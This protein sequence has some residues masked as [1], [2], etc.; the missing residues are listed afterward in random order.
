V[1]G[2][3]PKNHHVKIVT[4]DFLRVH[5][6]WKKPLLLGYSGGTDSKALLY[7]L[8]E[9]GVKPDLAHVDHGW[10]EE[11]KE[12]AEA[13]REEALELGCKFFSVRLDIEKKEDAARTA[14]YAYFQSLMKDYSAL[15]L[16]H[17]A[18]DLAETTLK[19]ILEGAHLSYL[20]GMQPVSHRYGMQIWR[21]LLTV[22]RSEI[23]SYLQEKNVKAIVDASN[24]NPIYLR[25]RMRQ[26]I[27][28]FLDKAFGKKTM[29]NLSL[30][31]KRSAELKEYLDEKTRLVSLQCGSWGISADLNGYAR[32]EQRHILQKMARKKNLSLS[33]EVLETLLDWLAE[34]GKEKTLLLGKWKLWVGDGGIF[35]FLL[36]STCLS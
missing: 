10:R 11:S 28:P 26:E 18:D 5:W 23:Y 31:S 21:P 14:R 22:K 19:R 7:A 30:L 1:Q 3:T 2:I 9:C 20:S 32:I 33:K 13:L 16:A 27:F 4:Y 12:E 24:F 34:K 6:D 29:D 8:L 25:T 17:Q 36:D 15:L 35:F